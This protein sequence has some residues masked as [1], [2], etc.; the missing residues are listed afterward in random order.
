LSGFD[1]E[2]ARDGFFPG[3]EP[4]GAGAGRGPGFDGA[5]PRF[6]DAGAA[7][8]SKIEV[9][10]AGGAIGLLTGLAFGGV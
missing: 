10:G 1:A 6:D 9:V 4:A 3:L 5:A 8:L 7:F 2:G